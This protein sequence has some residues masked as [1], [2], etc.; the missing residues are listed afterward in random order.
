MTVRYVPNHRK[1]PDL[2][3]MITPNV[4]KSPG[5]RPWIGAEV[6]PYLNVCRQVPR[7]KDWVV[8]STGKVVAFD[9]AGFVVPAGLRFDM[10]AVQAAGTTAAASIVYTAND[11]TARVR[12]Y[13]GDLATAGEAVVASMLYNDGSITGAT[14]TAS[15]SVGTRN[16][17][18]SWA[19]GVAMYDYLQADG[20]AMVPVGKS[21]N[22]YIVETPTNYRDHNYSR[23]KRVAIVCDYVLEYPVVDTYDPYLGGMACFEGSSVMHGD[24][25]SYNIRSNLA[26]TDGSG[27]TS[28]ILGQVLRI[29]TIRD[30]GYLSRVK[31]RYAAGTGSGFGVLDRMPG[32]ATSGMSDIMT[33]ANAT[34]GTVLVNLTTR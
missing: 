3:N 9:R 29:Q 14:G 26:L 21:S 18:V 4:E 25:V 11:V 22:D 19:I 28:L 24:M 8:V 13:N 7:D 31:T 6:A 1:F 23:Q 16:N 2:V 30:L 5:I 27:L 32:T 34:F 12:N 20:D 17:D 15:R 10:E 33:F